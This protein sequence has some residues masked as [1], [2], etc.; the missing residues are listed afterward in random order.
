MA[1]SNNEVQNPTSIYDFT[2]KDTYGEDVSLEKYRGNVVLIVNIASK[3]G[4]T[5]NNYAKLTQLKEEY[6]DKGNERDKDDNINFLI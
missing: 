6:Y 3:C 4:L 1:E 5:K 2:V